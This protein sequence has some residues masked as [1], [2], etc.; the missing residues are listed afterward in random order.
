MTV[1]NG[2]L[3]AQRA[4]ADEGSI[5]KTRR[6]V[7]FYGVGAAEPVPATADPNDQ[8]LWDVRQV[9]KALGISQRHV[10]RLADAG[11]MPKPVHLGNLVR[12]N[13]DGLRKWM[14]AGFPSQPKRGGA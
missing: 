5:R 2:H 7:F 9:A 1:P 3:E 13:A 4:D 14:E 6:R 10:Y 12:W 8:L 11:A